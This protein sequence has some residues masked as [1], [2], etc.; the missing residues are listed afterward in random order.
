MCGIAGSLD[1][2]MGRE[3]D[4]ELVAAMTDVLAH[5]GPDDAGLLVAP[6]VVLGHR[7]LSILDVSEAG[8][9][10]MVSRDGRYWITFNGEIFNYRELAAELRQVGHE[11]RTECDT[12]VL[13]AAY[14]H[15]GRE[16]FPRLN[17][18]FAFAVWD[19]LREELVCVRDRLGV[20]PLYYALCDG[21][22]RFASEIKGLLLDPSV[23]CVPNRPRVLD[24]LATGVTDHTDE[25]LFEGILQLPAGSFMI[26][27]QGTPIA[28]AAK[29]YE[30]RPAN[31]RK[32]SA[33]ELRERLVD[34]VAL[35]L[36]SDVP[37][38]TTLSGG[39]DSSAVTVIATEVRAAEGLA[40]AMTFSSRCDDPDLDEGRYIAPV[41]AMTGAPNRDFTPRV[42]GLLDDLDHLLWHMDEPFHSAA[43]YGHWQ[44]SVLARSEGVVVLLDGQGGDEALHG[45]DYLLYPGFLY[46]SLIRG[47][48]GR[49]IREVR[50]RR[51]L[52]GISVQ[53]SLKEL[54]KLLLPARNRARRP[55]PWLRSD[56]AP[57]GLP[58]PSRSVRGHHR[59]GLT[60]QPLPM[61]NHQLDRNTMSVSLEARNPFLD[62]RVVECGLALGPADHLRA[63]FSKWT[64]REALRGRL[65]TAVLD[66]ARKQGFTT[67]E[68]TW[69]RGELGDAIEETFRS[70]AFAAR[71]FFHPA[72]LLSL[73][74]RHRS[75]EEHA[76]EI[77]RAYVVE[78][79][80]ELFCDPLLVEPPPVGD[81]FHVGTSHSARDAVIRLD[82]RPDT[83]LLH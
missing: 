15:W 47:R 29:W 30:P 19:R 38:G 70:P 5:R 6:P 79:W 39:L 55:P 35:R 81:R 44:M 74:E 83:Q 21:R 13:V 76:A 71:P 69:I 72:E 61:Y 22:F 75:G 46:S 25:T 4:E 73:L 48:L 33:D 82:R 43:V 68:S 80:L 49:M 20:K 59:Y 42:T 18:M 58:L 64:L 3:P 51:A 54:V 66:R 27:R 60:V 7:R 26:V 57:A 8:H 14:E 36:R 12:E 78:R 17:G 52:K 24:F 28:A 23:A 67:D 45:Y 31:L 11:F 65:P 1:L 9:Q 53:Q 56:G 10:P 41:L 63:G 34:A 32:P 62:H 37:V 2:L 50:C 77:W 40:P 16:S